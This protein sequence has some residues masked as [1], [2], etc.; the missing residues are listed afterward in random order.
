[1]KKIDIC[2]RISC[3]K[4]SGIKLFLEYNSFFYC[5]TTHTGNDKELRMK[6]LN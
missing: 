6:L 1:M 5:I 4:S 2:N 3:R